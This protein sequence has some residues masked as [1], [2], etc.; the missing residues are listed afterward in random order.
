MVWKFNWFSIKQVS[1]FHKF[2]WNFQLLSLSLLL[3]YY[4][5]FLYWS[6]LFSTRKSK[7]LLMNCSSFGSF[8]GGWNGNFCRMSFWFS[9]DPAKVAGFLK[10]TIRS[11]GSLFSLNISFPWVLDQ[12]SEWAQKFSK[13]N[14]HFQNMM[15]FDKLL[16]F[17]TYSDNLTGVEQLRSISFAFFFRKLMC[18]LIDVGFF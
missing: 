7:M 11:F 1:D 10:V 14:W 9:P 18:L 15:T 6:F 12:V 5:H 16:T 2:K 3:F 17:S 4:S 13:F 8:L